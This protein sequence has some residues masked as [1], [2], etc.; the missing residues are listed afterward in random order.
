VE[1]L[2][3]PWDDR[4][5]RFYETK[6]YVATASSEQVRKPPYASSIGRWQHYT[7]HIG[8]MRAALGL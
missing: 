7:R 4:C 1:F 2:G 6:R 3:L 8:P 5:A